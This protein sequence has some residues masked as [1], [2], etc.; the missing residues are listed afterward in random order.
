LAQWKIRISARLRILAASMTAQI[1]ELESTGCSAETLKLI[2]ITLGDFDHTGNAAS[3]YSRF[4]TK[5]AKNLMRYFWQMR[6]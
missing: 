1:K 4:G 2:L 5:V 3:L 6:G